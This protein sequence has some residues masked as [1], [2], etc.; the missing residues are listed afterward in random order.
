MGSTLTSLAILKAN[1][2]LQKL[3]YIETFIPLVIS[4]LKE[5]KYQEIEVDNLCK[6]FKGKYGLIVTYSPMMTILNRLAKKKILKQ[7]YGTYTINNDELKSFNFDD[8]ASD[9]ERKFNKLVKEIGAFIYTKN[10][11]ELSKDIIEEAF[12]A[13]LRDHDLELLFASE[14]KSVLPQVK[15][16]D[17]MSYFIGLF[18]TEIQNS[19]P[20]LF[21][22]LTDITVGHLLA[23]VFISN[24]QSIFN[25]GLDK[26]KIFLDTP[27]LIDL[28][29][30]NGKPKETASTELINSLIERKA[31][32][33]IYNTNY[34]ELSK[35]LTF[36]KENLEKGPLTVQSKIN[37]ITSYAQKEGLTASDIEQILLK[38]NN[39][40]NKFNIDRSRIAAR[41]DKFQIDE[42]TLYKTIEKIYG[43]ISITTENT[44]KRDVEVLSSI[45]RERAGIE[46][47]S[48][49]DS[50]A[51]FVTTN[52]SLA[53]ASYTF[54][55]SQ[56]GRKDIIPTC[57]TN[58]FIGTIVWLRAPIKTENINRKKLIADCYAAIQ[59]TPHL[60][61]KYLEN[62]SRL[63]EKG[64]IS[65]DE[66]YLLRTHNSATKMLVEMTHNNTSNF[67][68]SLPYQIK[69]RIIDE[70]KIRENEKLKKTERLLAEYQ[71]QYTQIISLIDK[72]ALF[73]SKSVSILIYL[74]AISFLI[75]IFIIQFIQDVFTNLDLENKIWLGIIVFFFDVFSI[76][77]G[78]NVKNIKTITQNKIRVSIKNL[79]E[80]IFSIKSIKTVI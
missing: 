40:F 59:P 38:L 71:A 32:L 39:I 14:S 52:Q 75:I 5:K 13:F 31:K 62:I 76:F 66:Y 11:K 55:K 65:E 61:T 74:L 16:L 3:D 35:A 42:G 8:K 9:I 23:S 21:T 45:Y 1:W 54:Q 64:D 33:F 49:N 25:S 72:I 70:I 36:C 50:R 48:L 34:E 53:F 80:K 56:G 24:K 78:V 41:N 19:E 51:V 28:I 37:S 10:K 22:L 73:V 6:D 63:K 27:F 20:D 12:I 2:D 17:G 44:V 7:D 79:L 29:G 60:V 43:K 67:D 18:I 46:P 57:I 15:E 47:S 68:D 26:V 58:T 77:Y 30:L 4:L 69:D